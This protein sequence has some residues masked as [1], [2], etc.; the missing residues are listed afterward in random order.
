M[1]QAAAPILYTP[2][3]DLLGHTAPL[4]QRARFPLLGVLLDVQVLMELGGEAFRGTPAKGFL[5]E[6]A[7]VAARG[8]DKAPGRNRGLAAGANNDVDRLHAVPPAT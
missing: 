1:S 6:L 7:G 8:S 2:A 4:D 5:D 3:T